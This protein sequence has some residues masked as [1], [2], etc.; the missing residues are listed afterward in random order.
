MQGC[1]LCKRCRCADADVL[2]VMQVA[3][4]EGQQVILLLEDYQFVHP[5]FLEMVNS[6]LSSGGYHSETLTVSLR[7]S[8]IK[9][10][11]SVLV[12]VSHFCFFHQVKFQ[13]YT[14]QKS[15]SH[16]SALSKTQPRRTASPGRSTITSPS[17][18]L[19]PSP[20]PSLCVSH[21]SF[22]LVLRGRELLS[23]HY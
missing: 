11:S 22:A 12:C 4:L 9:P 1:Q 14:A 20:L 23:T 3:G 17:V 19:S 21:Y 10:V 2:Q 5:A 15:W 18:S 16:S 13:D 8:E 6:L 7:T